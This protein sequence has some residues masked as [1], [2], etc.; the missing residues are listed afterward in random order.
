MHTAPTDDRPVPLGPAGAERARLRGR[1]TAQPGPPGRPRTDRVLRDL[2]RARL[3]QRPRPHRRRPTDPTRTAPDNGSTWPGTTAAGARTANWNSSAA[4]TTKSKSPGSASRSAKSTTPCCACPASATPRSS[5]PN[6]PG[7]PNTSSPSTPAPTPCPSTL[8]RQHLGAVAAA[9]HGPHQLPPPRHPAPDR[10]RENRHQS[11]HRA[12]RTTR[13]PHPRRPARPNPPPP[14]P[15]PAW[16]RS[17]PRVLGV[18]TDQIGRHDH[19][20]DRGGTSLLAVKVAIALNREVSLKDLTRHPVL[21]EL[22]T[23]IDTRAATHRPA[24]PPA[25]R[26][27]RTHR[28]PQPRHPAP[29]H[30]HHRAG[31]FPARRRQRHQL[32]TPGRRPAR[33]PHRR[34]R[35]RTPR[36]RPRHPHEPLAPIDQI[37]DRVTEEI[38]TE[39]TRR[40]LSSVQLWGHSAGTA[41]AHATAHRLTRPRDLGV[42]GVPGRPAARRP[43]RPPRRRRRPRHPRHRRDHRAAARHA[44]PPRAGR[45]RPAPRRTRRA[46]PTGTTAIT[47]HHY[48]ADLL[49]NPDAQRLDA[50]VTVRRRRGRPEHRRGRSH[51]ATGERLAEHVEVHRAA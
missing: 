42:A 26:A 32:P 47:A 7:R 17:G 8:L 48:F 5:W 51:S 12:G 14:P 25:H 44:R 46:P 30:R 20:F 2:R 15:K 11:P 21:S 37:A 38:S 3:H 28:A 9:L 31:L 45:A 39:L 23:L 13:H 34:L 1:R 22:A 29:P 33:Q 41:L 19:F 43:G 40:G 4:A 36:T 50:P 24:H 16:P 10:Q 49:D 27:A 18:A 35:R 6:E